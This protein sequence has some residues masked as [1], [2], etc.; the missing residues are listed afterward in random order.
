MDSNQLTGDPKQISNMAPNLTPTPIADQTTLPP[1]KSQNRRV[2]NNKEQSK[3]N[4]PGPSSVK[5]NK[6]ALERIKNS[7]TPPAA[8]TPLALPNNPQVRHI[9]P[10]TW[11]NNNPDSIERGIKEIRALNQGQSLLNKEPTNNNINNDNT[12]AVASETPEEKGE[13]QRPDGEPKD[14]TVP[15][16]ISMITSELEDHNISG[17][18]RLEESEVHL[19]LSALDTTANIQ[20]ESTKTTGKKQKEGNNTTQQLLI[21]DHYALAN[22]HRPK[23]A[24]PTRTKQ[25]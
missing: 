21:T 9:N 24:Q 14:D 16:D 7:F 4:G 15:K 19:A 3:G 22:G 12:E 18:H 23:P 1:E 2:G 8:S 10:L 20:T 17:I 5:L 25:K 13:T 11:Q 6:Q